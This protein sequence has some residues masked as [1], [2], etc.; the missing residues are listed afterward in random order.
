VDANVT[1]MSFSYAKGSEL[2]SPLDN[3]VLPYP[4]LSKLAY[5][6]GVWYD[7][8]DFNAR[9]AYH[10][11]DKYYS[12][13]ND[14]SGNPNFSDKT[15]YLD[16]KLQWKATKNFTLAVEAKNLTNQAEL[17]YAGDLSRPNELAWSGRRYYLTL[18]YK[19]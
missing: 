2:I 10:H 9:L 16:A 12:G 15:A 3:S 18:G 1:R 11:R 5:N 19:L 13:G 14:V 4:G 8:G 17:T 7:N 6:L